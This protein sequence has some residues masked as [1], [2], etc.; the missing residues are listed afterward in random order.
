MSTQEKLHEEEAALTPK[1]QEFNETASIQQE[2]LQVIT[3]AQNRIELL[4]ELI[5]EEEG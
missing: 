2:R 5:K 4:K 3:K 1:I